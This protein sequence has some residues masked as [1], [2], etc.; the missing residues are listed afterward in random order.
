MKKIAGIDFEII[1]ENTLMSMDPFITVA[2]VNEPHQAIMFGDVDVNKYENLFLEFNCISLTLKSMTKGYSV[3]FSNIPKSENIRRLALHLTENCAVEPRAV[4]GFDNLRELALSFPKKIVLPDFGSCGKI[5]SLIV[6]DSWEDAVKSINPENIKDVR[7]SILKASDFSCF[8]GFSNLVTL[9]LELASKLKNLYGL[10]KLPHLKSLWISGAKSLINI[11][12]ILKCEKLLNI[13][14]LGNRSIQDFSELKYKR[15]DSISMEYSSTIDWALD[16]PGIKF[17][18][19]KKVGVLGDKS[20]WWTPGHVKP[21]VGETYQPT[22]PGLFG[23]TK[24]DDFSGAA[25]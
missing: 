21:D 17:I 15:L 8:A 5:E 3:N 18:Y 7:L 2:C 6:D 13:E 19:C 16:I 12:E 9:K 1:N 22:Y 25:S 4:V 24:W 11:E 23:V 10:S 14:V 20:F